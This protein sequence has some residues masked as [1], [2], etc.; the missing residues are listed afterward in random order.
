MVDTEA[1]LNRYALTTALL[2]A[3]HPPPG[4][5]NYDIMR[6]ENYPD[7]LGGILFPV[8]PGGHP[9]TD[10]PISAYWLPQ[11]DHIEVPIA[12]PVAPFIFT[13]ELSG[14]KIYVNEVWGQPRYRIFHIQCPRE[15]VEYPVNLR[16]VRQATID[17]RDY[18]TAP[19]V[20]GTA[21]PHRI[22]E[23]RSNVFMRFIAGA[24]WSIY[25]QGLTG[26]G[27]GVRLGD[28]SI[29]YPPGPRQKVNGVVVKK[30]PEVG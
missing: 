2:G 20:D 18:G 14:C 27:P 19:S 8:A 24:G 26:I 1:F 17:S 13:P 6:S 11:G 22:R 28:R 3:H 12:G 29:V 16:G 25:L 15:A 30:V 9:L 10:V 23:I 7:D 4:V 5:S 21:Y